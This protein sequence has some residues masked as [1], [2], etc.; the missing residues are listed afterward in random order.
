MLV[1]NKADLRRLRAVPTGETSGFVERENTF[2]METSVLE[3]LNVENSFTEIISLDGHTHGTSDSRIGCKVP[4]ISDIPRA[5]WNPPLTRRGSHQP[6]CAARVG[7]SDSDM[8]HGTRPA[9][10]NIPGSANHD[11][12]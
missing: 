11:F 7:V 10:Y 9:Q 5:V 8:P 12:E 1:E 2:F 6:E 3:A 4:Y